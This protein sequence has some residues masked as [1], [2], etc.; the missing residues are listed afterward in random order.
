MDLLEL[1]TV[2]LSFRVL[3]YWFAESELFVNSLVYISALLVINL[4]DV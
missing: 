2:N 4:I 1:L 3:K